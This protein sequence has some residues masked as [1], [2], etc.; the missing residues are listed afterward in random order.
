MT[1]K[2]RRRLYAAE[3]FW[4]PSGAQGRTAFQA[5]DGGNPATEKQEQEE[6]AALDSGDRRFRQV[7]ELML[8]G[9]EAALP[10]KR[11]N[12]KVCCRAMLFSLRIVRTDQLIRPPFLAGVGALVR[13]T[14][15]CSFAV[16]GDAPP[17][18]RAADVKRQPSPSWQKAQGEHRR[19]NLRFPKISLKNA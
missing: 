7:R 5:D 2:K 15:A 17:L 13:K 9:P 12:A 4:V 14:P 10:G 6:H 1:G 18:Q 8:C 19:P 11:R 16:L 3:L